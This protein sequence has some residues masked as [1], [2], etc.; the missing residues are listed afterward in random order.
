MLGSRGELGQEMHFLVGDVFPRA[1]RR[2][3]TES[4]PLGRGSGARENIRLAALEDAAGL[5]SRWPTLRLWAIKAVVVRP[6]FFGRPNCRTW[7]S[8]LGVGQR[9]RS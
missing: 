5:R 4:D 3:A 9:G 2:I 7:L 8:G 1:G 6:R